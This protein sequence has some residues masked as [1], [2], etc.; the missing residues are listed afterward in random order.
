MRLSRFL[1]LVA[2]LGG[3]YQYWHSQQ[4]IAAAA[5]IMVSADRDWSAYGYLI[6]RAHV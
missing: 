2:L 6:G 4:P 5:D 1:L 3:S